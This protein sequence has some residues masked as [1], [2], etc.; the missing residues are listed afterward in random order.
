MA[1]PVW[2]PPVS[3]PPARPAAPAPEPEWLDLE[4]EGQEEFTVLEAPSPLATIGIVYAWI[5]NQG[6]A[7]CRA[8]FRWAGKP[9]LFWNRLIPYM[10]DAEWKP[11]IPK[12]GPKGKALKLVVVGENAKLSLS[13]AY[14]IKIEG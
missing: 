5:G 2:V 6:E 7:E 1:L 12:Y 8:G 4:L 10:G 13:L 3:P 9:N 14:V 11:P